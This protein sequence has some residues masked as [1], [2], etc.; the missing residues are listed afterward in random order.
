MLKQY[1]L[2][3]EFYCEIVDAKT[4][5]VESRTPK[6]KNLI[7][8]Q[9]LD[10]LAIRSFVENV[11]S[12][13]VSA[14]TVA[15]LFTD[16]G[17]ISEFDRTSLVDTSITPSAITTLVGNIYSFTRVFKFDTAVN[18]AIYGTIGW[19]YSTVAGNNLFSKSLILNTAG[20]PGAILVPQGKYLRVYYT[21]NITLNPSS[22]VNGNSNIVGLPSSDGGNYG[23]QLIGLKQV[24]SLNT[25]SFWDAGNDCNELYS[26][27]EIFVG[28]SAAALAAFGSS[29]N[30][31]G[32][33]NYTVLS[34]TQYQGS[35][36][37]ITK[38]QA[39]FG[40]SQAVNTL[41][42]F[43]IGVVGSSPTN[44]GFAYVFTNIQAKASNFGLNPIFTY[45]V[46]RM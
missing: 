19:S 44:S 37:G 33:T 31:S 11:S 15:P 13:A 20:V 38:K 1:G 26:S 14:S 40:K 29:A 16:T 42:S 45:S 2:Y 46:V 12:C 27:A 9:G 30:R 3:G 28:T 36:S 43:G 39:T 35:G 7:L 23:L 21:I 8:N 5:K 4:K 32:G 24:T 6:K 34:S 22:S 18:P 25:I 41:A 17:L 10:F